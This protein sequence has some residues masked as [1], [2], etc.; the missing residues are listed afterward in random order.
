METNG[1]KE[2]L[3]A[4]FSDAALWK[5]FDL[6]VSLFER[7]LEMGLRNE[8]NKAGKSRLFSLVGNVQ[9]ALMGKDTGEIPDNEVDLLA[10]NEGPHAR[11]RGDLP[12]KHKNRHRFG[13]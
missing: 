7:L 1:R 10:E 11:D 5:D 3:G 4:K 9:K 12:Q 2:V 8:Q 6:W 13:D